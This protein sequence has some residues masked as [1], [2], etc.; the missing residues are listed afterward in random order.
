M[1]Q[2]EAGEP[3]FRLFVIYHKFL[4]EQCYETL[5][6]E[7]LE[8]HVRFLGVNAAV[9]KTV[10][11]ALAD[12]TIQ[13]RQL[14]WYNPFLQHNRLCETSAFYHVWKNMAPLVP[15]SCPYIGFFHYDM[16]LQAEALEQLRG[17]IA[18]AEAR[19][20]EVLFPQACLV[21]RSHI[22]QLFPLRAW[23]VLVNI[24]NQMFGTQHSIFDVVDKEIPLYHSFVIH[25]NTFHRMMVFADLALGR[26]FELL[27]FET[28]HLP[29]QVERM[30]G[31]FLALQLLDGFVKE[32]IPLEGVIH[33]TELKDTWQSAAA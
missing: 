15:D 16:L 31:I 9:E 17:G 33:K 29:Y 21:A 3:K 32:W 30:H 4:L 24:Y 23:D 19:G 25:R 22:D 26:L 5:K 13:E 11:P 27:N 12:L 1:A 8:R 2:H 28:R 10:P 6:R 18:A 7:E 14:A 20:E